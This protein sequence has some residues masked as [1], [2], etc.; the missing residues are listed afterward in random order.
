MRKTLQDIAQF[1]K[2]EIVGDKNLVITGICGIKDAQVGDLSFVANSKY[3]SLTEKTKASALIVPQGVSVPGKSLI[4]VDNPSL[5]F[6][7]AVSLFV[8]DLP[9]PSPGIHPTAVVTANVKIGKNV[10]IGPFAVIEPKV[11]IG[12]NVII[13]S[14]TF[15]GQSAQ[16]GKDSQIYPH[17]MI[18]E[19]V[20]VG[21]RVIIHGGTAIGSDGFGYINIQGNHHK[22]PQVGTVV[23]EDDVEIGS[24]VTVDR[25]RF[26]KTVIGRG[27]KIDNLVHIAHNVILG[28]N[29]LIIAQVGISGSVIVEDDVILAGQAG[30]AGHL[31]IGKGSTVTAQ[32]GVTKS[33]PPY[34]TLFGMPA[35]P[36]AEAKKVHAHMQRLPEYVKRIQELETKISALESKLKT[37]NGK[38]KNNKK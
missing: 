29:C 27:T 23:V 33:F 22:I 26:G 21:E 25:A 2:G 31:T 37:K 17:V 28:R 12:D 14:G 24:N 36:M 20:V 4:R 19:R 18:R 32:A 7:N 13:G 16:I 10:A 30:V 35:R 5:A 6:A 11:E 8:E 9:K 3:A 34:S 38:T 15:I 1:V